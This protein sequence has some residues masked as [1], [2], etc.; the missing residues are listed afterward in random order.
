[1]K[2]SYIDTQNKRLAS[3]TSPKFILSANTEIEHC[4]QNKAIKNE[5]NVNNNNKNIYT[6]YLPIKSDSIK[7][8]LDPSWT[9]IQTS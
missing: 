2:I 4:E 5:I 7:T 1:M 8:I 6:Y 3:S 9:T